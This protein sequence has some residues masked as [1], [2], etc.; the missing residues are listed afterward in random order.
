MARSPSPRSL[1]LA[2]QAFSDGLRQGKA[3]EARRQADANQQKILETKLRLLS[4]AGQA[5]Q[6]NSAALSSV[7]QMLDEFHG[8]L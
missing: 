3:E 7:A 2:E 8:A 5:I 1:R 4:A 6:A